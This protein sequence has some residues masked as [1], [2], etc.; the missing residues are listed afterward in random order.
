MNAVSEESEEGEGGTKL[1]DI[2]DGG[3]GEGSG[4]RDV[5]DQIEDDSQIG[6]LQV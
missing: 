1:Q 2:T 5:T 4:A 6:E 3:L